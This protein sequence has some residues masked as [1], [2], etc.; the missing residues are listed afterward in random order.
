MP[1]SDVEDQTT[2]RVARD[3]AVQSAVSNLVYLA[4]MIGVTVGITRRD[5]VTQQWMRVQRWRHRP[6]P[7]AAALA[8]VRRDIDRLEYGYGH[9]QPDPAPNKPRRRGLF[10]R[11]CGCE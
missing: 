5:W 3:A 7:D 4:I 11:G 2:A 6:D 8:E 1:V 10:E 9:R